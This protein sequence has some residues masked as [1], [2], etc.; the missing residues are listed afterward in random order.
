MD[1]PIQYI[2]TKILYELFLTKPL[3]EV[4]KSG[5]FDFEEQLIMPDVPKTPT[6]TATPFTKMILGALGTEEREGMLDEFKK[7]DNTINLLEG[8]DAESD[9]DYLEK[10]ENNKLGFYMEDFVIYHMK[11]P[12]CHKAGTLKKY[13]V[14]NMPVVDIVCTN[15]D[16]HIDHK[17][18]TVKCFL[19]QIKIK[20]GD[21]NYFDGLNKKISVGSK[22]FGF[23]AHNVS[24]NQKLWRKCVVPGYIC[25]TLDQKT[26][27]TYIILPRSFVVV[28]DYNDKR[29]TTFYNYLDEKGYRG[30]DQIRWS[31]NLTK[32]S[33]PKFKTRRVNT[34]EVFY[35]TDDIKN[36]YYSMAEI[37]KDD[38]G[39]IQKFTFEEY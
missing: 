32:T 15:T 18:K 12:V 36:E 24:G 6:M 4:T 19:F 37:I 1:D 33:R 2:D 3:R 28:P 30:R 17:A 38:F 27:T 35:D 21:S 5:D 8:I 26:D 14:P 25:L 11:C 29:P 31:S 23:N 39:I 9:P 10:L 20:V 34:E 13:S 22:K 7:D 16:D